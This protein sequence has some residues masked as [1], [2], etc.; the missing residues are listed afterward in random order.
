MK[1]TNSTKVIHEQNLKKSK[2][3]E[4]AWETITAQSKTNMYLY[5]SY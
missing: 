5:R 2:R 4:K 3:P 1:I